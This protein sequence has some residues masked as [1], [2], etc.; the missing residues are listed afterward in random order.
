MSSSHAARA[1]PLLVPCSHCGAT[2]RVE[3]DRTGHHPRCGRCKQIL[4]GLP[5]LPV[6]VTDATFAREVEASPLPVLVDFWAPW[7][8]PCRIVAPVV[9]QLAG[10]RAGRLKVAKVNVDEN[11]GLAARFGIRSIPTLALFR[12]GAIVEQIQGAVPRA[13]LDQRL[14]PHL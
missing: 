9:E 14:A 13:I 5:G 4:S 7:C 3:P 2:N 1:E 11:P 10:D 8:G 6:A 12:N